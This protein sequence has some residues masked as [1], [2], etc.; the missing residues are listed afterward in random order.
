MGS[1]PKRIKCVMTLVWVM[2]QVLGGRS[3]LQVQGHGVGLCARSQ[4]DALL[5]AFLGCW[6]CSHLVTSSQLQPLQ[7]YSGRMLGSS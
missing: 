5:L 3:Y 7:S 1:D 2:N 4:D 6:R